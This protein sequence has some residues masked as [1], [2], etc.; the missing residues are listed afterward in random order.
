MDEINRGKT[1]SIPRPAFE[2]P[3][4]ESSVPA[5]PTGGSVEVDEDEDKDI[6]IDY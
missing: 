3:A 4:E 1:K 2:E 5:F 6:F